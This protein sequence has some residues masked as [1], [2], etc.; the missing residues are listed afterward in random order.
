MHFLYPDAHRLWGDHPVVRHHLR[1]NH[2][3]ESRA[4]NP[5]APTDRVRAI[6]AALFGPIAATYQRVGRGL[7]RL[8]GDPVPAPEVFFEERRSF[9]PYVEEAYAAFVEEGILNRSGNAWSRG[10]RFDQL[11]RF[12]KRC[13][14]P[15]RDIAAQPAS[16]L[17]V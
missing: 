12:L 7:T 8:D 9:K 15:D 17:Q 10:P 4:S 13:S 1:L 3:D 11:S 6:M 14:L 2:Y 5:A 16:S